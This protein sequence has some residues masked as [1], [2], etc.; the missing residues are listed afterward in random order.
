MNVL[1][2]LKTNMVRCMVKGAL[3]MIQR[4]GKL[5]YSTPNPNLVSPRVYQND[6]SS[7]FSVPAP[8]LHPSSSLNLANL[9]QCIFFSE[10]QYHDVWS[11]S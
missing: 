9:P 10:L 11:T 8:R 7:N 1:F 3:D 4:R 6:P 2:I 5:S